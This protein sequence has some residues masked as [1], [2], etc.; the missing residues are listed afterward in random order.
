MKKKVGIMTWYFGANYGA[1]AQSLALYNTI[2]SM[3]FDCCMINY[4]PDNYKRTLLNANLPPK[5]KRIIHLDKTFT[6]LK[7]CR[8]LGDCKLFQESERVHS[9]EEIDNLG[10]DYIVF[11]SDAIFNLKHPLCDE[12]YYGV[13]IHTNKITYSPSCEYLD[14]DEVLPEEY[15]KSLK[16][17]GAVSVRD[18]NTAEF[19]MKNTG[20]E[21]EITL[22]PTFLYKFDE[23]KIKITEKKYILIYAFSD[24]KQYSQEIRGY[25]REKG[26]LIVAVGNKLEWSDL[27]LPYA[28]FAEW[29]SAFVY[30][31]MVITD[32]FHGTVFSLK[33][34]KQIVLCGRRDK[35]SKIRCLLKQLDID[36]SM[37]NGESIS[38]YLQENFIDYNKAQDH[39]NCEQNKSFN[40]LKNALEI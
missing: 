6:G 3:G 2:K 22:D 35:E 28:T 33:N 20:I 11:G 39:I 34:Q 31:E 16:E 1:V 32:S 12:I 23:Y 5:W 38:T 27:S 24:W 19:I 17:M 29:V 10:L 30:A 36:V 25:A 18:A 13:D 4:R 37:Y 7:K 9:A 21:S 26:F 15:E 8:V 14:V 40:Y